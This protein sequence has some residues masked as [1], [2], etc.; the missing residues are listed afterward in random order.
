M[1]QKLNMEKKYEFI[2]KNRNAN[3]NMDKEHLIT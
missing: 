3:K 2:F 1:S